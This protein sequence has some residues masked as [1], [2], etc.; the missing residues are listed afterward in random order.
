LTSLG[1]LGE[2]VGFLAD[3]DQ[4]HCSDGGGLQRSDGPGPA[5][6][7]VGSTGLGFGVDAVFLEHVAMG[8]DF[9]GVLHD[10]GAV[11]GSYR[12]SDGQVDDVPGGVARLD[13]LAEVKRRDRVAG[14]AAEGDDLRLKLRTER[15]PVALGHRPR[16]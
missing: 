4:L 10:V 6:V 5:G 1:V 3:S 15:P 11:A 16:H 2:A 9:D 14:S 13:G 8:A 12:P 7:A